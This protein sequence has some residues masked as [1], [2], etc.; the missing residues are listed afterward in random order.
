MDILRL[1]LNLH[2]F[3]K[4]RGGQANHHYL[5]GHVGVEH[6]A[7]DDKPELLPVP[8]AF[9]TPAEIATY[10]GTFSRGGHLVEGKQNGQGAPGGGHSSNRDKMTCKTVGRVF[11]LL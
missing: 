7:F 9:L 2:A 4:K 10:G 5:T 8:L 11:I 6:F 1:E 3:T